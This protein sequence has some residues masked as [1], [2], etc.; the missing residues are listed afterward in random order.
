MPALDGF[1]GGSCDRFFGPFARRVL[2]EQTTA[3]VTMTFRN[4]QGETDAYKRGAVAAVMLLEGRGVRREL[5]IFDLLF[6]LNNLFLR[7][8][9][10][11]LY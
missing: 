7:M 6:L 2:I 9:I 1:A 11:V 5:V 4:D 3:D 10:T 8:L